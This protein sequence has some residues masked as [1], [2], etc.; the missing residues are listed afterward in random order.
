MLRKD[1]FIFDELEFLKNSLKVFI[2]YYMIIYVYILHLY[3][4]CID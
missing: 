1:G 2:Y 3:L 4:Q